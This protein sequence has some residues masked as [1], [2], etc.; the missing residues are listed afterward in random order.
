MMMSDLLDTPRGYIMEIEVM[1]EIRTT[2][3][4]AE[5][6]HNKEHETATI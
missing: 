1:P 2:D 4:G 3:A 5:D 6:D